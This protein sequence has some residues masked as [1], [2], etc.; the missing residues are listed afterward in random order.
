MAGIKDVA[1]LAG[2]STSTV[3]RVLN[4]TKYVSPEITRKVQI[5]AESLSY[6][7]DPIARNLKSKKTMTIGILTAEITGL[8]YPYIIES[9]YKVAN[10]KKYQTIICDSQGG[11]YG[12]AGALDREFDKFQHMIRNRVDGIIFV[13]VVAREREQRYLE[14]LKELASN[15]K[16]IPIVSLERDFSQ[17]GIDSVYFNGT[18]GAELAVQHLIDCGCKNIA[19]ITGPYFMSIVEERVEGYKKK[20][21]EHEIAFRKELIEDGNYTHLSGYRAMKKLYEKNPDIDGVFCGN[22]QMAIGA[23]KA[24]QELGIRIPE[25]IK[26]IGYDD[27]FI[28]SIVQPSLST[29]HVPRRAAGLEVA[30]VLFDRIEGKNLNEL[31]VRKEI[32]T[33]LVIR[34]STIKDSPEDWI[35]S[36]W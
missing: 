27:V 22:D 24:L 18:K 26:L 35:L 20:L 36:E 10:E 3:S 19:H 17:W 23:M 7:A 2:V 34:K 6:K 1:K 29:I 8:F 33:R 31:P 15:G 11:N 13:S 25:D 12:E 21:A 5:A 4:Q 32:T 30:N 16:K 28:S 9:I 14:K